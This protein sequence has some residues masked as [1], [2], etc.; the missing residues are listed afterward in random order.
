MGD[1]QDYSFEVFCSKYMGKNASRFKDAY[2]EDAEE[3]HRLV[4]R[5][6]AYYFDGDYPRIRELLSEKT[7]AAK[8]L[9][10]A[11]KNSYMGTILSVED[12]DQNHLV[13]R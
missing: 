8:L 12:V 3:V 11:D 2:G 1:L 10:K 13:I 5:I 9:R 7:K 6:N 4:S